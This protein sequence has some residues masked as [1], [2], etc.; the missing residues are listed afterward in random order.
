VL[1]LINGGRGIVYIITRIN[2]AEV[3]SIFLCEKFAQPLKI[4][5]VHKSDRA[6]AKYCAAAPTHIVKREI[7][8]ASAG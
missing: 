3:M 5:R 6:I 2:C 7:H 8:G 1:L 4:I